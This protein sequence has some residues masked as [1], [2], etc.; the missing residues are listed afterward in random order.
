MAQASVGADSPVLEIEGVTKAFPGVIA[1]D[2]VSLTLNQ[3]EIHCLLGE[4]GAGKSTLMNMVF[5][6]HRPDRGT[7]RVRG[8]E[9]SFA[10]SGEAIAQGIG[11]VH[12]HFQLIPVFTVAENIILGNEVTRGA[13]LD[14]DT[15][16]RRIDSLA[17]RYGLAVD[18]DATVGD[19]SVGEQQRVELVKALFR[20][21]DI[22]ILDEPT[23]V[24]TPGEVDDFFGVVES[25]TGQGK[26]IIFI[27]HKLRE[28]LAVAD[29]ITV[30]RAGR[31]VGTTTADGATQQSLANLMVGRDVVFRVEKD[32]P[33]PGESVMRIEGLR[34]SDDRGVETVS[35]FAAEVRAGEIF[36]IAGVEGNGQRELVE[37][38]CGMRPATGGRIEILGKNTTAWSPR[39]INELGVAHVPENRS[40]HG[41]VAQY[42]IA[43]NMVLNRYHHRQF[44]R[45]GVRNSA[46]IN[47]EAAELV[48]QFDVRT[49]GVDVAIDTLSGGNQQKVIVAR[50]LTG[51]LRALVVA[52]PTRGLDVGSIEFIHRK[53][54]ELRD[55]GVAVLLVS[56]ELDEILSLSDRIGVLYRGRLAGTVEAADAT[57]EELGLLMATGTAGDQS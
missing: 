34:V 2:D 21:A 22:L 32:E 43:D 19:L 18:P 14:L 45:H 15:A 26:S 39:K 52:Q 53:I 47:A 30:L 13:F 35:G 25:L 7:I 54:I 20:D 36:G 27:T 46:A 28:V 3:G 50:E 11:M 56:A 5:G 4:N 6:L 9:V 10:D 51:N 12:Q 38:V 24:L 8:Q 40:K 57:R 33:N 55:R 1:N 44:A 37:A 49:P 41:V 42:T 29:R 23:A 16:R 48:E 31:V 17:E